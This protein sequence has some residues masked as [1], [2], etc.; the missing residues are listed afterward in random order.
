MTRD[1]V[2]ETPPSTTARDTSEQIVPLGSLAYMRP[3]YLASS[4]WTEHVPFAFWLVEALRPKLFVELGTHFGVS[5]FAFCQAMEKLYLRAQAFA[6]DLWTGDEHSGLYGSDVFEAVRTHNDRAY[7]HFSTLSKSSFDDA[8][9]YFLDGSIDLLHIDG[10][11]TYEAVRHDF[12][13]WL[14]KMSSRGVVVFHDTNVR[15][16]NFGVFR[17]FA[18]LEENYPTFE[19]SHGHGLGIVGV[20]IDQTTTMQQL[21]KAGGRD[22]DRQAIQN[23]FSSLGHGCL[24]AYKFQAT[25]QK[26]AK[27]KNQL[28]AESTKQQAAEGRVQQRE[29][30]LVKSQTTVVELRSKLTEM[31]GDLSNHRHEAERNAIEMA[32]LRSEL[33]WANQAVAERDKIIAEHAEELRQAKS[34]GES[35]FMQ[36]SDEIA[37]LTQL[38]ETEEQQAKRSVEVQNELAA[39]RKEQEADRKRHAEELRQEKIQSE[40]RLKQRFDEITTLT[41]LL[42]SAGGVR[43]SLDRQYWE[44][45]SDYGTIAGLELGRTILKMVELPATWSV[46]PAGLRLRR[47]M[48]MLRQSG[49][50]DAK[51]YVGRY[52]DVAKAGVDP[53]RHYIQYGAREGREPNES[54]AK[55][56]RRAARGG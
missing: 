42:E 31:E 32:A 18:E 3:S 27:I 40:A 20:G 13:S 21:F 39:L 10:L 38:L 5:Y 11:H 33:A 46:L 19:F 7:S 26:L 43:D 6:V 16:R 34:Q 12:E 54:L 45:A 1:L 4:A 30:E 55:G 29:A 50:F 14:P 25:E 9:S 22:R 37:R 35:L 8:R 36:R 53:V 28:Q 15:E 24:S 41:R 47:Q 23:L 48:R 17:L 51:W 56:R 44:V 52:E 2:K 49:L